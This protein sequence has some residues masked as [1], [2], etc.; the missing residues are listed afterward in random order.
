MG[1]TL[2]GKASRETF[3][4]SESWRGFKGTFEL[5]C[6]LRDGK[7]VVDELSPVRRGEDG[8]VGVEGEREGVPVVH[9]VVYPV[10]PGPVEVCLEPAH[11]AGEFECQ[12][13]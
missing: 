5:G 12:G 8:V 4:A 9:R 6:L 7:G 10:E 1:E 11:V 13:C 3:G 2:M